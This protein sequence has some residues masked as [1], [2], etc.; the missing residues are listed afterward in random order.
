[1]RLSDQA[2]QL[3]D[4]NKILE[5]QALP[6]EN[7][8][9]PADY[10]AYLRICAQPVPDSNHSVAI[11]LLDPVLLA[12]LVDAVV[13][14]SGHIYSQ[15]TIESLQKNGMPLT[16][17]YTRA[18]LT[19]NAY[20]PDENKASFV[21]LPQVDAAV[22]A[23]RSLLQIAMQP[24]SEHYALNFKVSST[25]LRILISSSTKDNL[26][27]LADFCKSILPDPRSEILSTKGSQGYYVEGFGRC[28][29]V[30]PNLGKVEF[31]F[32][33]QR[34]N[35]ED[36]NLAIEALLAPL[37][38]PEGAL[39]ENAKWGTIRKL[40]TR[41]YKDAF[42]AI[43]INVAQV[44]ECC[45]SFMQYTTQLTAKLQ[46][47]LNDVVT[48]TLAA[49]VTKAVHS[50]LMLFQAPIGLSSAAAAH[51]PRADANWSVSQ[52]LPSA[53]STPSNVSRPFRSE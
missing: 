29:S 25:K 24:R 14:S 26:A 12:G 15:S 5:L 2:K 28:W 4:T 38:L 10:A 16:C 18:V 39:P 3:L 42:P 23:Y 40:G 49:P 13:V 11:E 20:G 48:N 1:M 44:K 22:A 32:P 51:H 33:I 30:A 43:E 27:W 50:G 21:H 8:L 37:N 46:H 52:P 36:V 6:L 34:L 19:Q 7:L 9:H 31:W 35:D 17:P 45:A 53:T 41:E 47:A